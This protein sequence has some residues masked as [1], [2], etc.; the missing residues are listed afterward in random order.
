[1]GGVDAL[2]DGR[3]VGHDGAQHHVGVATHVF[4]AGH[5]R[6]IG[7]QVQRAVYV[8]GTPG[9][10]GYQYQFVLAR[11]IGQGGDI[12]H[13]EKQGSGRLDVQDAGVG[14]S[15]RFQFGH[16]GAGVGH[17]DIHA[18]QTGLVKIAHG[19]VSAVGKKH[20]Y[21]AVQHTTKNPR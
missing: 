8:A 21:V 9:V 13:F 19:S 7:A 18:G 1:M 5:D 4:S 3:I 12:E 14:P 11:V 17:V 20:G 15:L 10:V 2:A 6:D 16:D